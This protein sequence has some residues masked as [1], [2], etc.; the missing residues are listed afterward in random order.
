MK[1]DKTL[2]ELE[3][4]RAGGLFGWSLGSRG[5]ERLSH[6]RSTAGFHL[7]GFRKSCLP[8]SMSP[9]VAGSVCLP[10]KR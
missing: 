7:V 8:G 9:P 1:N 4:C 6:H 10:G 2:L 3:A 5:C